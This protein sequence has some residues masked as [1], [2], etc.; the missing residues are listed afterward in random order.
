MDQI[1]YEMYGAVGDGVTDDLPAI[2]K[3]HEEAN[4]QNLPVRAREGA[5][6]YLSPR[7]LTAV[8]ETSVD[9]RGARFIIDDVGCENHQSP[10]FLVAS[11]LAPVAF[12]VESLAAGQTSIPNPTG[13]PLYLLVFN[14]EHNDYIRKGLNQSPGEPRRDN[15][16]LD[17]EGRL[18]SPVSFAFDKVTR[19]EAYPVDETLLTLRGGEFLTIANQAESQYNYHARNIVI[20]R[21]N[22]EVCQI[23]HTVRG[24]G[25]H[26]APYRGFLSVQ[27]SAHVHIHDC[28]F[29]GHKTYWTIG[30]A[31]LPVPMGSYD[32]DLN[33]STQ[34]TL[35]R[36]SQTNDIMDTTYWGLIGTN[37]CRELVLEDCVFSRF[38]AHC[39]VTNCIL[40]R[41]K[42]GHQCLNAIGFG[43]FLIEDTEACGHALVNLREDYGS[44][45]RGSM[46]IR[47]CVWRPLGQSRSVFSGHNDGTHDFGYQCC[48]PSQ[49]TIEGLRVIEN[50]QAAPDVPL[51]VFNDYLGDSPATERPFRPVP[52]QRVTV[53]RVH[54]QR[55]IQLC[56]APEL[57][58]DTVFSVE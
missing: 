7:D 15:V 41:C 14:D 22:V 42:L 12:P 18:S 26:G 54:T 30:S 2:V 9:W 6:Y 25:E 28:V 4:R 46:T 32:I 44:T 23:R 40:R 35:S 47:N 37:F 24:E 3:A 53:H 31:H 34:V 13:Q 51:T 20:R 5:V 45:W 43:H 56:A 50:D 48:M 1:T 36:C 8:V 55:S 21:S 27:R 16:L 52:P 29:T 17:G 49:V 33:A 39:G 11:R 57:M 19:S 58:P 10:I 38:D